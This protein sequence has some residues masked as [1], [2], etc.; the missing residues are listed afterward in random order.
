[1]D[2][3]GGIKLLFAS[4]PMFSLLIGCLF[5]IFLGALPGL[6]PVFILTVMLPLTIHLQTIDA[7]VMLV[8]GYT[9]GVY[10][11]AITALVFNVP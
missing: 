5:G 9:G 7:L 3:A 11:G 4:G 2:W 8:A 6:G 1:M 10:G